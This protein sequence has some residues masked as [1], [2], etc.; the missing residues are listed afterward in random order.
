[1]VETSHLRERALQ[2]AIEIDSALADHKECAAVL[3]LTRESQ[4]VTP[5]VGRHN[6]G[7]A[8]KPAFDLGDNILYNI[9]KNKCESCVLTLVF[10]R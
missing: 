3:P 5:R 4:S 7:H 9:P 10:H 1:M 8:T 6:K 2:M